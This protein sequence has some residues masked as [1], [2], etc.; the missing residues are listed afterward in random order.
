MMTLFRYIFLALVLA[1]PLAAQTTLPDDPFI[2][3]LPASVS[4]VSSGGGWVDGKETGT[5]RVVVV[6][7]GWDHL[8]SRLYIQWLAEDDAQQKLTLVA[9]AH[10]SEVRMGVVTGANFEPGVDGNGVRLR[11]SLLNSHSMEEREVELLLGAKG[12][13]TLAD[14][15]K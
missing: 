13:Y 14:Q 3:A 12:N 15:T 6:T 7:E 4:L 8:Q 2:T 5:Y 10:V 9:T 11:I 1:S